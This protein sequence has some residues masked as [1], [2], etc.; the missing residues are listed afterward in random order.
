[1]ID[2]ATLDLTRED[3]DRCVAV[4]I[5]ALRNAIRD[6]GHSSPPGDRAIA[7]IFENLQALDTLRGRL[8]PAPPMPLL[9]VAQVVAD[10]SGINLEIMGLE[11]RPGVLETHAGTI[12]ETTMTPPRP[13]GRP[14]K[15]KTP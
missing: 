10:T 9:D 14:R 5:G 6:C 4:H 11:D 8:F 15:D 1:M 13:R 3:F 7:A 2:L 12:I